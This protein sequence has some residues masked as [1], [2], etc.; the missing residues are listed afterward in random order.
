MKIIKKLCVALILLLSVVCFVKPT[1]TIAASEYTYP[2]QQF[3]A[4][5]VSHFAGDISKYQNEKVTRVYM[6]DLN[7]AR[8]TIDLAQ[9][10]LVNTFRLL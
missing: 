7:V 2:T 3:R 5:W 9:L 10:T 8:E 4:A 6:D 1:E